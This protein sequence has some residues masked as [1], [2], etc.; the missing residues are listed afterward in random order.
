MEGTADCRNRAIAC[1]VNPG[2]VQ[3]LPEIS[4]TSTTRDS[5]SIAGNAR[6]VW[7]FIDENVGWAGERFSRFAGSLLSEI[8]D[9][10]PTRF[11]MGL[12]KLGQLLGADSTRRTDPGV[13]DVV[14]SFDHDTHI[15]IEAKTKKRSD[16]SLSKQEIQQAVGHVNWVRTNLAADPSHSAIHA[17]VVSS[18]DGLDKAAWPHVDDLARADPSALREL[19]TQAVDEARAI[20]ASFS[21]RDYAE[22]VQELS[23]VLVQKRLDQASLVQR[24]TAEKF[25]DAAS[26]HAPHTAATDTD[27]S[28]Q[29]G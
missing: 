6:G 17:I 10:E 11:H 20:R 14:W 19:A 29:G 22:A 27:A 23:Q 4:G 5:S 13:P 24:L 21:G 18:T 12:E 16:T 28:L 25:R 1:G 3:D 2:F 26:R 9:D 8:G 7:G 15:A